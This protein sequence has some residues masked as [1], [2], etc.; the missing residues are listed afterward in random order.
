MHKEKYA[1][2]NSKGISLP[3]GKI[4]ILE[5]YFHQISVTDIANLRSLA[6]MSHLSLAKIHVII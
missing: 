1:G 6:L 2:T 5:I 4:R 3:L